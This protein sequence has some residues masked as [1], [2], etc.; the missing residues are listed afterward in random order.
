[1]SG[2]ELDGADPQDEGVRISGR[3]KWFDP[4]KGYG[5]I[6]PDDP[7]ETGL[8]DVLLHVTSLR[9]SGHEHALE[10][11]LIQCEAVRRAKGWQVSII[12]VRRAASAMERDGSTARAGSPPGGSTATTA[13]SGRAAWP[14]AA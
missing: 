7:G 2:L 8:K 11:S 10:G 9:Q 14:T 3:V 1:M 4:A 6:V 12:H 13:G 5:F